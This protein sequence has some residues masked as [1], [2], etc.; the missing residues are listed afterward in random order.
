[1]KYQDPT[2]PE[3]G[4]FPRTTI[5]SGTDLGGVEVVE[6]LESDPESDE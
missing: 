1:M 6:N 3:E 2:N 4:V 5:H